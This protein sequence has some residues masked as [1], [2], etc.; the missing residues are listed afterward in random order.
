MGVKETLG[1]VS[2]QSIGPDRKQGDCSGFCS[3]DRLHVLVTCF[4][5]NSERKGSG[6]TRIV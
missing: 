6:F 3:E 1:G 2:G 4:P 5:G